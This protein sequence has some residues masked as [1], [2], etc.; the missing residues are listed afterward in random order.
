MLHPVI[1]L[2]FSSASVKRCPQ[3]KQPGVY[4]IR[5]RPSGKLYIGSSSRPRGLIERLCEHRSELK[6]GQ[7]ENRKLQN[8]FTAHSIKNFDFL[9][10]E[11]C[12]NAREREQFYL[13]REVPWV[14]GFNAL[15]HVAAYKPRSLTFRAVL[16]ARASK[17]FSLECAG[18]VH[19]GVNLTAFCKARGLHQGAM[20]QVL[21]GKKPQFK[22]WTLP[23]RGVEPHR[24]KHWPTG[25]VV[26]IGYFGGRPF[27]RSRGLA[28][29]SINRL[30]RGNDRVHKGWTLEAT[31]ITAAELELSLLPHAEIRRINGRKSALTLK[32][33]PRRRRKDPLLL[34][35]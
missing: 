6:R 28:L 18:E 25:E 17:P 15:R 3:L 24:L 5:H 34:V 26:E 13:D 22:G 7:H 35:Q 21:L 12:A 33:K 14:N 1:T 30:I 20:T 11:I 4:A 31:I 23:G 8:F 2:P 32:G 29:A 9:I 16:S 19:S 10:V 27:A